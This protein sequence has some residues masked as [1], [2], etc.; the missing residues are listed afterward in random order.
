M[1]AEATGDPECAFATLLDA[2]VRCNRYADPYVWLDAHILDALCDLGFRHEH[3]ETRIWVDAMRKLASRTGMKELT[4]RAM[5]HSARMG[6]AGDR[7]AAAL[8]A[9][10]IDNPVLAALL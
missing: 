1:V 10:E 7:S 3:P 5:L 6:A 8:I 4:A 2:R 9:A